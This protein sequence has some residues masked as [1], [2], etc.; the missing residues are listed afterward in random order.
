MRRYNPGSTVAVALNLFQELLHL[1]LLLVVDKTFFLANRKLYKVLRCPHSFEAIE[2]IG[3]WS[4]GSVWSKGVDVELEV[5]LFLSL[6]SVVDILT[7]IQWVRVWVQH[8]KKSFCFAF[9]CWLYLQLC[10]VKGVAELAIKDGLFKFI[11]GR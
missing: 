7:D 3:S 10:N 6:N 2:F 5:F 4:I 9:S 8:E 1:A 11:T